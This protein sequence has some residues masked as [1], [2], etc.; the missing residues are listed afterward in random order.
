MPYLSISA[1]YEGNWG[2]F[3]NSL[4]KFSSEAALPQAFVGQQSFFMADELSSFTVTVIMLLD[5]SLNL[6]RL[7][8]SAILDFLIFWAY[9]PP[10]DSLIGMCVSVVL[11]NGFPLHFQFLLTFVYFTNRKEICFIVNMKV[12]FLKVK[13]LFSQEV[14]CQ[15][16][17]SL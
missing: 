8:I 16:H 5:S 3:F 1:L 14:P 15:H 7:C 10:Q 11:L 12:K 9:S 2:Y 17:R 6:G 4:V 13:F